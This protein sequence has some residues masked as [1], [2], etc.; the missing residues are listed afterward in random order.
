MRK[1]VFLPLALLLVFGC[2]KEHGELI[3][4]FPLPIVNQARLFGAELDSVHVT[5]SVHSPEQVD[6]YNV[7]FGL[8]LTIGGYP[9]EPEALL[10]GTVDVPEFFY[11][12][13]LLSS[14][15]DELCSNYGYCDSLYKISYFMVST[16]T[17]GVEE[18]P[19]PRRFINY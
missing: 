4:S 11:N 8:Y 9:I 2:A 19:G 7:Y 1:I 6:S 13:D 3:D 17:E 10:A 18:A 15:D 16:V 14:V 12:D 5:W